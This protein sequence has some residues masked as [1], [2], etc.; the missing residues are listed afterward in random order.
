MMPSFYL[1]DLISTCD[2][3]EEAWL[4]WVNMS[5]WTLTPTRVNNVNTRCVLQRLA[6]RHGCSN[7]KSRCSYEYLEEL[8]EQIRQIPAEISH[9]FVQITL[10][11][12]EKASPN[13]S[14]KFEMIRK[15]KLKHLTSLCKYLP[16]KG[17]HTLNSTHWT[18]MM[19]H[20]FL[21]SNSQNMMTII[22][23]LQMYHWNRSCFCGPIDVGS[24]H[25]C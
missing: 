16:D 6:C 9:T 23:I 5:G 25:L 17:S 7:W 8:F 19:L 15:L 24:S 14:N 21:Q 22:L 12:S 2:C 13:I 10:I 4:I 20:L 1:R 11:E 3:P 18:L